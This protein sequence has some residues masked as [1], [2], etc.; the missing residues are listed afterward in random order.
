MAVTILK[1]TETLAV[2]K[3]DGVGGTLTLATN[4]LSPTMVVQGTPT[5]NITYAQWN[6]SGGAS[7]K[8]VVVRGGTTVLNLAQ[9]AG[10]LDMSGNGG[11]A[12]TTKNT[13]NIVVTTTGTGECYLTLRKVA[14]FKSKIQPE[15]YGPNDDINSIVA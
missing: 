12:E 6:I 15:T 4:L 14:G 5:V 10:E 8:I 3:F 13:D 9:N 2:V 7:D 11:W 1:Q